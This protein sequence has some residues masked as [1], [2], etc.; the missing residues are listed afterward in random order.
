LNKRHNL[1]EAGLGL[2]SSLVEKEEVAVTQR[3]E[4]ARK[5]KKFGYKKCNG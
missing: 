2:T 3:E 4:T 1:P 5:G